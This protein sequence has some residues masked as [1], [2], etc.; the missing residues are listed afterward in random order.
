MEGTTSY[1][2]IDSVFLKKGLRF[3]F[4]PAPPPGNPLLF[5][6]E[7]PIE[8][9]L[10]PKGKIIKRPLKNVMSFPKINHLNL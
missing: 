8:S 6:F 1:G 9:E 4:E 10:S 5:N 2:G 7:P 3:S